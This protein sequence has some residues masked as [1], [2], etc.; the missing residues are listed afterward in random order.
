LIT[1]ERKGKKNQPETDQS[2]AYVGR[3]EFDK[4]MREEWEKEIS[5]K[6][7]DQ[8]PTLKEMIAF[9]ESVVS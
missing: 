6:R 7:I 5:L 1:R 8:L 3:N 4:A 9:M 2:I